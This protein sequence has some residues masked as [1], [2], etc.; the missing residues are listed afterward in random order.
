MTEQPDGGLRDIAEN[1]TQRNAEAGTDGGRS[2]RGPALSVGG[3]Q[4]PG[5]EV[6]P[7]EGRQTSAPVDD[8]GSDYR[9][10]VR[11]GGA[12]GPVVSSGESASPDPSDTPRG[13]VAGPA[14][15]RPATD[16]LDADEH[17]RGDHRNDPGVGPAH[18]PGTTRAEDL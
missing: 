1:G 6:P 3:E 14:D 7:Y 16:E 9:D 10:G 15:E 11:V 17:D 5:G 8:D 12:T 13:R 18:V 2:S 4:E